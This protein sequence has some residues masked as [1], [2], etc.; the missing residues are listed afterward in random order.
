MQAMSLALKL[1]G[2]F[3]LFLKL[4]KKGERISLLYVS[5]FNPPP[6]VVIHKFPDLS[7]HIPVTLLW[8]KLLGSSGLCIKRIN[9]P[10]FRSNKFSPPSIVPTHKLDSESS[11]TAVTISLLKLDVSSGIFL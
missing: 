2:S 1:L 9:L 10:L 7:S 11:K 8:L 5:L 4:T 6:K 3:G